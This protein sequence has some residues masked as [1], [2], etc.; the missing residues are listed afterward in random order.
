MKKNFWFSTLCAAAVLPML[1]IS[2][3]AQTACYGFLIGSGGNNYQANYEVNG[4]GCS[5]AQLSPVRVEVCT[6]AQASTSYQLCSY[7][8]YYGNSGTTLLAQTANPYGLNHY[9]IRYR[10]TSGQYQ[11]IPGANN[12]TFSGAF[13]N[14]SSSGGGSSSGGSSSGGNECPPPDIH[15][16]ECNNWGQG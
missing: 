9:R 13:Y 1:S 12:V 14:S 16:E 7:K 11:I 5:N 8:S 3:S 15:P 10:T 6:K 2:A 4:S